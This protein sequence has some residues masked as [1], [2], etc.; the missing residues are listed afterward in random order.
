VTELYA[1]ASE[2]ELHRSAIQALASE[3]GHPLAQVS[4]LWEVELGSMAADVRVRD[5][6]VIFVL[7]KTREALAALRPVDAAQRPQAGMP[8]S[9]ASQGRTRVAPQGSARGERSVSA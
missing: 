8:R 6:L 2:R 9:L 5:Y 1:S 7:R 4:A 3:T